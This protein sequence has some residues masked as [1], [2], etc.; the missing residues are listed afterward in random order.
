MA[1]WWHWDVA[2]VWIGMPS[3]L[4][5][6]TRKQHACKNNNN[7]NKCVGDAMLCRWDETSLQMCLSGHHTAGLRCGRYV[8]RCARAAMR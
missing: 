8:N 1:M 6:S 5:A 4:Y 7:N 3:L 2:G